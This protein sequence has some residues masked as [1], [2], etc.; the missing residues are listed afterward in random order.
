M[1]HARLSALLLVLALAAPA[2][3]RAEAPALTEAAGARFPDRSYALTLPAPRPLDPASVRVTENG[4]PVEALSVLP[5][6]GASAYRFGVVLAIDA[7]TSMRGKPL[8]SAIAAARRFV[9]HRNPGQPVAIM[10]FAGA[11]QV[12]QPFTTDAAAIDRALSSVTLA[13][14]GTHLLDATERAVGLLGAARI[15]SGAVILISDGGDAGSATTLEQVTASAN[16]TGARVFGIGLP[17]ER[18]NFGSLN[19]LA[20]GTH[21]EFSTVGSASDLA[22]LYDR[23]GSR[24]AGQYL[25]RYRSTAAPGVRVHV[26]V[27]AAGMDGVAR[28]VYSSPVLRPVTSAPFRRSPGETLWPSPAAVIGSSIVVAVL[29]ASAMVVLLRPR[30][31]GV[32]E[33]MAAYVGPADD[34]PQ[35][36]GE[37]TGRVLLGAAR[38]IDRTSWGPRLAERLDIARMSVPPARLVVRVSLATLV[39]FVLLLMAGGGPLALLALGAPAGTWWLINHRVERQRRLFAEQLPDNLQVIASAMRAGHSFS[40]ALNVV[41]EEAPEP[42][43]SELDR[44]IADERLGVPVEEALHVV[45]RRMANRDLEQVAL[46][47]ALQRE[48]GGNT[49]EVLDRVTETVR[50]RAAL[51]RMVM[52]LT[53]QGRLSRWVVSALP[54]VL[55]GVITLINPD[56]VRPLYTTGFGHVVLTVAAVMVVAGSLVIKRIVDIKV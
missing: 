34:E 39:L 27:R 43:R 48:T 42:T 53:A 23:L 19:L 47:A 24:L 41:V 52:T 2:S 20:A 31:G 32:R 1:R 54:V 15:S 45:V 11:A 44:V 26:T 38:S 51:R 18:S 5:A 17:S 14:G 28:T 30:G 29:L 10:T 22:R 37:L 35:V 16:R 7:S 56:Y 6:D 3:A 46:V 4:R 8:R 12:L 55:L 25:I 36:T 49:A 21:A 50:E 9:A 13:G 40:G 33:R